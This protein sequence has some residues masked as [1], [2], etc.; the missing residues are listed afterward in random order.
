MASRLP[1]R[2]HALAGV[3]VFVTVGGLALADGGRAPVAWGVAALWL[4]WLVA[5]AVLFAACCR[6]ATLELVTLACLGGLVA[7][8]GLST[9]WSVDPEASILELERGVVV[10]AG[11]TALLLLARRGAS[12]AILAGIVA[13]GTVTSAIALAAG[14]LEPVGYANALGLFAAMG[15]IIAFGLAVGATRRSARA[16]A[17]AAAVVQLAAVFVSASRGALAAL[18]LGLVVAVAL[19]DRRGRAAVPVGRRRAAVAATVAAVT[20]GLIVAAAVP[21]RATACPSPPGFAY[22]RWPST[23]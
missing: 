13:A 20:V 21:F 17:G 7:W 14:A 4:L 10:V 11:L 9:L 12:A 8:T 2:Q 16:L 22:G 19:S 6:L 5:A 3:L 15:T 18:A 23:R 1:S